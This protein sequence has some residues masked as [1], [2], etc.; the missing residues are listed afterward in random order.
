MEK[1]LIAAGSAK[2]AESFARLLRDLGYPETR[3]SKTGG[4][5]RRILGGEN[6]ALVLILCPLPGGM[7]HGDGKG[8]RPDACRGDDDRAG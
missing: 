8:C 1:V 4:E 2:G 6:F 5:A 7:R 3:V